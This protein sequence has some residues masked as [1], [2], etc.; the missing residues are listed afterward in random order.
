M[1]VEVESNPNCEGSVFLRFREQGP[2]RPVAQVR[3]YDRVSTG[4]WCWVTGW[5]GDPANAL[6]PAWAL[7]V[8]DS[9]SGVAY[10]VRGGEWGLRLR[11]VKAEE[12]WTLDSPRQW[13]EAY[14]LLTDLRDIRFADTPETA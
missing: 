9:G 1:Y 3:L 14:L 5:Q 2:A 8:E 13:G 6:C 7:P 10:L 4:E 11:P 12:P